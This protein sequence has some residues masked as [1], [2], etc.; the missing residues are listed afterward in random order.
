[1]R[2]LVG[3]YVYRHPTDVRAAYERWLGRLRDAG[4]DV[5]GISVSLDPDGPRLDWP[6][7]EERWRRGDRE[8]LGLYERL[9]RRAEDFDVFLNYNG[10]SLHPDFVRE[11]PTYNVYACFD[12]P[13]S[14]DVMSRPV[15]AAYDLSMVGNV[16][17]V[18]NY[19]RWGVA[20]A[21]FWPLGFRAEDFDPTLT[22]ER[23]LSGRREVDVTLLCE[24]KSGFRHR[25][26]DAFVAAF[27]D[28]RYFGPGWPSGF[29]PEAERVPLYQRTKIG[30][31]F[32]NSTGPINFRTYALPAN[33]VLQVCDNRSHLGRIFRLGEEVV[34]FDDVSEAI[35]LCRHYLAH[36][37]ERRRIAAAGWERAVRDYNETAVF[38]RLVDAVGENLAARS[39]AGAVGTDALTL[40]AGRRRATRWRRLRHHAAA[41]LRSTA[42]G[43]AAFARAGRRGLAVRLR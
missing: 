22:R 6:R 35:E 15:A 29:L 23:I 40:L 41:A 18:E 30:P 9:A 33:G 43:L 17:E 5:A 31:N 1:M 3:Y 21:R 13:E 28:G 39:A 34:G 10:T 25:R 42:R 11:L 14:S 8:L 24:R 4:F 2:I 12:D 32:H 37:D 20:D 36:D 7:I 26:L 27:P 38:Q 16:A 19:R